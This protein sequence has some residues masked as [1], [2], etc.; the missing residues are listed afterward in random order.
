MGR[1]ALVNG[2]GSVG[3]AWLVRLV[4]EIGRKTARDRIGNGRSR[5]ETHLNTEGL[6]STI[7][8]GRHS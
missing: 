7:N 1:Q 6:D 3:V 8:A 4:T 2:S 5:E